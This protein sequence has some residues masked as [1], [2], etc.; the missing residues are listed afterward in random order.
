M[1]TPDDMTPKADSE[2]LAASAERRSEAQAE[3]AEIVSDAPADTRTAK[4]MAIDEFKEIVTVVGVALVL[5]LILRTFL[6]Q[7]FTIP[8]ASMEPNLYSGDYIIVSKWNYGISKY[9][10]P[11][12]FPVIKGR[13]FNHL[14]TRGDVVVFKLPRDPH[15]DY[16]KRV[17]GLPGDTVQ[18]KHDRLYINGQLVPSVK[19][20]EVAAKDDP[21]G[22]AMEY[23]ESLPD[24]RV[25]TI[26]DMMTDGQADDTQLFTVPAGNYFVMGDNR[27]NSLDSRF[28]PDNPYEPGVGFVPEAN[29]EGRAFLILMSWKDGSSLWKPWT[30]LNFHWDRFFKPIH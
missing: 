13:W 26:Q 28:S 15:I 3:T 25:H 10:F 11:I 18:M 29:L 1:T 6:F 9:S 17:I 22:S 24:G 20:G 7:P 23:R 2:A 4:Q 12:T 5:V 19:V 16:I 14:P 21:A 8:S 30:W 27:D